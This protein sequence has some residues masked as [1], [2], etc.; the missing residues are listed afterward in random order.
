MKAH[1]KVKSIKLPDPMAAREN[2]LFSTN[3]KASMWT[4]KCGS[5]LTYFI[6]TGVKSTALDHRTWPQS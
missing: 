4:V 2:Q 3:P 6:V 1:E 5:H